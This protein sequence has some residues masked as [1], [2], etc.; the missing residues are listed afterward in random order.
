MKPV[1]RSASAIEMEAE[2]TIT[3]PIEPSSTADH[4]SVGS[5]VEVRRA[6]L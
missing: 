4:T 2:Y 5:R 3:R 6:G 1:K